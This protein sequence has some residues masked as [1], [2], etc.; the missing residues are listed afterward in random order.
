MK[1]LVAVASVAAVLLLAVACGDGG[2]GNKIAF[3]S[4]RDGFG[5]SEIYVMDPDGSGVTRL[6]DDS[7]TDSFPAWSPDGT[8]I[9]FASNRDGNFEIYV[10]NADGSGLTHLTNN[11]D[12]DLEPDWSPVP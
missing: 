5:N 11:P 9:A 3:V 6:T 1:S 8:R 2:Q 4:E 7:A 10:V 12:E